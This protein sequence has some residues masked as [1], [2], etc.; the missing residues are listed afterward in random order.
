MTVYI[1]GEGGAVFA[2]DK[3]LP[4]HIQARIDKGAIKL[5]NEDGTPH[6]EQR[7]DGSDLTNGVPARPNQSASKAEWVAYAVN[8]LGMEAD[9]ADSA[10]KQDLI[11]LAEANAAAETE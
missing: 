5:V 8:A 6:V 11:D 7:D 2:W 9:A 10:T 4:G 3:P 1:K